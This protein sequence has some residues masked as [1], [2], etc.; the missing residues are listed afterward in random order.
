MTSRICQAPGCGATLTGHATGWCCERCRKQADRATVRQRGGNL[1][2]QT[3][4]PGRVTCAVVAEL[5]AYGDGGTVA[6]LL[7]SLAELVDRE[8]GPRELAALSRELRATLADLRAER[9]EQTPPG[10]PTR[11]HLI[12]AQ[13]DSAPER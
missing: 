3:P 7:L 10:Q 5:A 4:A 6:A 2:T 12:R 13:L 8:P 11:L 9:H 1:A